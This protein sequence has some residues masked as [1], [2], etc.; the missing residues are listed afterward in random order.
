MLDQRL[1]VDALA[2]GSGPRDRLVRRLAG[3]V[4]DV[5]RAARHVGDH[6]GAVGR[7][8][9]DLGRPR[10]GM[11][12]GAGDALRDVHASACC[13]TTS[14]FSAWTSGSGAELGAALEG[15]EQLVV[16]HHQRAL[17]GHEVLE[18]VDAVV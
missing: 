13:A 18:G 4:H 12:L 14:P 9:L 3:G 16:V 15:A 1:A 7:L 10:I 5:E 17:V 2:F 8:A 6:D 11:A